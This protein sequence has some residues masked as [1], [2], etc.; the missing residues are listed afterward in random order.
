M[1]LCQGSAPDEKETLLRYN[2]RNSPFAEP[3]LL[4]LLLDYKGEIPP[5]PLR[6]RKESRPKRKKRRKKRKVDINYICFLPHHSMSRLNLDM[7]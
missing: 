5:P 7:E 1:G 2:L 4:G 6:H 3:D